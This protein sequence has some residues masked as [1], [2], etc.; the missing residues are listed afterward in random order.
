MQWG[1]PLVAS[2][3]SMESGS[4]ELQDVLA[5]PALKEKEEKEEEE[6]CSA[7]KEALAPSWLR[8]GKNTS[9]YKRVLLGLESPSKDLGLAS[10][11][12]DMGASVV[13]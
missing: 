1:S 4:A 3:G 6:T 13:Q 2:A 10:Q 12:S 7:S 11:A 8:G 5:F 9:S